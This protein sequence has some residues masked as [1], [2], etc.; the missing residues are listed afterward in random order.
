MK[1]NFLKGFAIVSLAALLASCDSFDKNARVEVWLTDAPGDYQEVNVDIDGVEIHA[2]RNDNGKGWKSLDVD[3]RII[4]LLDLT[5][6]KD[7]LLGSI[8][9]PSGTISQIRL[10]LGNNNTVKVGGKVYNLDIPSGSQSGLKLLV[11]ERFVEGVTYKILLDFDVARSIVL[12][13]SNQY[14]LKPVIRTITEATSGSIKGVVDPKESTP[15]VYA[16]AG[17]DT[18]GTTYSDAT[19]HFLLRGIPAG[20]YEVHFIPNTDYKVVEKSNMQVN[21]GAVTDLE[22]VTIPEN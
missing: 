9:L 18:V 2:S 5:N 17:E 3:K 10:K 14:K 4:N 6:G 22:T 16:I 19:G 21:V 20:T 13:G 11:Q 8:E 15:A 7:T 12:T 1:L